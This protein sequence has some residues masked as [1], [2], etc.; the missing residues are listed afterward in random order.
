M[1]AGWTVFLAEDGEEALQKMHREKMDVVVSDI[2]MP[3]MDGIKLHKIVRETQ[4]FETM[5]FLF[6]SGFDDQYTMDA[7]KNPKIDG[8][9]KKGRE[10]SELNEW[11]LYLT[12][13]TGL[14]PKFPPGQKPKMSTFD[15]YRDRRLRAV[16]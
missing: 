12:A 8:F 6:V 2:Y 16:R 7:V 11:I 9:F 1:L 14:R 15:P 13:P 5:P 3:V 10:V 4:G